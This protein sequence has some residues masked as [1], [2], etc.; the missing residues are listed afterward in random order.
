VAREAGVADRMERLLHD[1]AVDP[2]DVEAADVVVLN[3]V[4]CCYPDY[5]RLLGAAAGHAR[6]LL[7]FSHP[8]RNRLWRTIAA[9]QNVFFRLRGTE[10]RS[11]AHPP[12]A[13]IDVLERDGLRPTF[14][15]RGFPFRVAGLERAG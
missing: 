14:P 8:P 6:R 5:E 13:M 2:A 12:K 11:F 10:F 9:A 4:V 15:H 3:R 7:V 1:I